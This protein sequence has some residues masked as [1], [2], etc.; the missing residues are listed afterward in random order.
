MIIGQNPI[1]SPI[2]NWVGANQPVH[3]FLG[4]KGLGI[5]QGTSVCVGLPKS[6]KPVVT[7]CGLSVFSDSIDLRYIP[8]VPLRWSSFF[9]K[10]LELS[11][12][13][14]SSSIGSSVTSDWFSSF[15]VRHRL[16]YLI[17]TCTI[18]E[19]PNLDA[20]RSQSVTSVKCRYDAIRH[21]K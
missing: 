17:L 2:S 12:G 16:W 20:W 19:G 13:Y 7:C 1:I 9:T 5:Q 14:F 21:H 15:I 18:C 10:V 8:Q 6:F 4:G 11:T 3:W